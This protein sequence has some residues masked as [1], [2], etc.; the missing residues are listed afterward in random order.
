MSRPEI[1]FT[2]QAVERA[3][4]LAEAYLEGRDPADQA[5]L[6]DALQEVSE[7]ANGDVPHQRELIASLAA[8][9]GQAVRSAAHL[10]LVISGRSA[11]RELL[12]EEAGNVLRECADALHEQRKAVDRRSGLER[13]LTPDRRRTHDD[14]AAARVNRW[15]H[16]DRRSG[17]ERRSGHD[18][19]QPAV[20]A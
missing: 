12:P 13:R 11:D 9:A 4:K 10:A 16:G 15:L 2:H 18:R 17:E 19:R 1:L 14:S 5:T 8:L 7:A 20:A 6:V 3:A